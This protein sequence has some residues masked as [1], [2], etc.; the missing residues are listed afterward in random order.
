MLGE[1]TSTWITDRR[2]TARR[3]ILD[4]AWQVAHEQGLAA[5][6]LREVASRVGIRAPSLYSH[7]ESKHAIYD[8]MFGESWQEFLDLTRRQELPDT[9]RAALRAIARTYVE[10]AT[11]DLAR[12][13]LMSL[14]TIPGFTPSA[15]SYAP[16]VASMQE[17]VNR[18]AAIGL[19]PDQADID[20]YTAVVAGLVDQQWANDPGGDRWF[21]LLD[22]AID[23]Y[24]DNLEL[25]KEDR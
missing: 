23:M 18:L 3:K 21:R 24:A 5:L 9:P 11:A 19:A 7:F 17:L 4:A 25:P 15:D 13:Q 8:A 22:R 1:S 6:T 14:R 16:A 20:L 2:Q 12:H 10:F